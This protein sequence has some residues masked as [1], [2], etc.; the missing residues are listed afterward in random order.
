MWKQ[1]TYLLWVEERLSTAQTVGEGEEV[2]DSDGDSE[3]ITATT[4]IKN[5]LPSALPYTFAKTAPFHQITI[6]QIISDFGATHF[7]EALCTF[8]HKHIS[9]CKI[10]PHIFDCFDVYK[11]INI[12]LPYNCYLSNHL[13]TN[14][15]RTTP[16][17]AKLGRKAATAACFD[18][19]LL[20]ENWEDHDKFGGLEGM[21][22]LV[23]GHLLTL[24]LHPRP[25]RCS[26]TGHFPVAQPF[27]ILPTP[28]GIH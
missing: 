28:A 25:S 9:T 2:G 3:S 22:F 24:I 17:T 19:A 5:A 14:H 26:C 7:L 16:A 21:Y 13:W 15:I 18:T 27:W 4:T 23:S 6:E 20:V 8:L 1:E 10:S 12:H 11:Q